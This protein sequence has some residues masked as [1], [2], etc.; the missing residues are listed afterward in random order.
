MDLKMNDLA[1]FLSNNKKELDRI[2]LNFLPQSHSNSE[3]SSL[4]EMMRDYPGRGGKGVRGSMCLLWSQMFGGSR[5]NSLITAAALELFQNWILIH[6]DIEDESDLRRGMPVLHKR[7]GIPKS[8]NAGDALHGKMWQLLLSN[9]VALG[10]ELT[11][12]ILSEFSTMLNE[13]TEGQQMELDWITEGKWNIREQDYYLMV[14]KKSAWYTCISPQRLGF[15]LSGFK[16]DE[17]K[18][19]QRLIDLGTNL[20]IAFQIVDDILNLVA[21][22]KKYGKEILGDL[23]EGK[24]TLMLLRL[25]ENC[26][27]KEK[28]FATNSLSKPR[29]MKSE[30]EISAVLE[31]MQKH[32]SI[33][34]AKQVARNYSFIAL[35]EYD[36]MTSEFGLSNSQ[37][38]KTI[39]LLME[40]LTNRDY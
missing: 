30:Q 26:S 24:R 20:G 9:E 11:I 3:I 7:Y 27:A 1:R 13:T 6:D 39:R 36:E 19:M 29:S 5:A 37:S 8:I 38:A 12:R 31:L 35:S 2:V 33:D 25:F 23:F 21:D 18:L 32:G 4:Y 34:Y 40:Y 28:E 15:I 17:R 16:S 10:S 14:T 22:P